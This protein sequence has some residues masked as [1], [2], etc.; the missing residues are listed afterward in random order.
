MNCYNS[1]TYLREAID[2]V[3]GQNYENWELI[4]WDNNSTDKSSDILLS[5]NDKR[6]KYFKAAETSPLYSARNMALEQ[7]SGDYVGFLDCDDIW[8]ETK[9]AQQVEFALDGIDIIYGGYS[10]ID[11]T[12]ATKIEESQYLVSGNITNSL[13]KRNSISI[14]CILIKRS[15]LNGIYF[16]P[17]YDLLG[18]YDMWVRLSLSHQIM[19]VSSVLEYS[20]Q[21]GSNTSVILNDKWLIERRYFYRKYLTFF[22]VLK[23]PWLIYYV[24]KTEALGLIGK[25]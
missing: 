14:G 2:S 6:I 18:D 11:A 17:Y 12:G 15:L 8:A 19:A 7:C 20:R 5:Y 4:F 9:L 10:T 23:Y 3:L 13:F 16:D 24:L 21:H 25:R 22:N 1:E